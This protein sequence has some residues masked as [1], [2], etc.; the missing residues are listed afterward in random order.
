MR[1]NGVDMRFRLGLLVG[2]GV[3]YYLGAKA[4]RERYEQIRDVMAELGEQRPLEKLEALVDLTIE[5]LRSGDD[6]ITAI[7]VGGTGAFPPWEPG[8]QDSSR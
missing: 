1:Y 6:E 5:R 7:P 4:G 2:F 3:G 8:A